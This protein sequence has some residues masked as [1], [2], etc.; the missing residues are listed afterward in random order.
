VILG[1]LA[2][3]DGCSPRVNPG[4]G[5]APPVV[6]VNFV[7]VGR[8]FVPVLAGSLADGFEAGAEALQAGK[9]LPAADDT[10]KTTFAASRAKAFGD[11][12]G[13]D[14]ATILPEGEELKDA[15]V[16]ARLTQAWRDIARGL[17]GGK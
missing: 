8:N 1:G 7:Q 5:P 17:R 6:A 3:R 16:R 14:L 10:L 4:P 2:V 13:K 9:P 11:I 15:A 12:V